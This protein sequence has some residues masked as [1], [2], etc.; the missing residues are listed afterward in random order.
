MPTVE[1]AQWQKRSHGRREIHGKCMWMRTGLRGR[2]ESRSP[3]METRGI[4]GE[5]TG[6]IGIGKLRMWIG[7]LT[8]PLCMARLRTTHMDKIGGVIGLQSLLGQRLRRGAVGIPIGSRVPAMIPGRTMRGM[9]GML[10]WRDFSLNKFNLRKYVQV[11]IQAYV[12]VIRRREEEMTSRCLRPRRMPWSRI[13][14]TNHLVRFPVTFLPLLAP[15]VQVLGEQ[16]R[17][18]LLRQ[19]PRGARTDVFRMKNGS[20][21][22]SE[23]RDQRSNAVRN[24]LWSW[25]G[26]MSWSIW[27]LPG[28]PGKTSS[29]SGSPYG[30][31]QADR[32]PW[33]PR[34]KMTS[35][36]DWIRCSTLE[37][38]RD[39]SSGQSSV[40]AM[41]L[42]DHSVQFQLDDY[43]D[44][45]LY[46]PLRLPGQRHPLQPPREEVDRNKFA[47]SWNGWQDSVMHRRCWWR[48]YRWHGFVDRI[49]VFL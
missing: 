49:L 21:G 47:A 40:G 48:V 34:R 29:S 38:G 36:A 16:V 7:C 24:L 23:S 26:S 42:P 6:A 18:F 10:R 33:T 44:R 5:G 46:P 2:Q 4:N 13:S 8:A 11:M 39:Q 20:F 28:C 41:Q 35:R 32:G 37:N 15:R 3:R 14:R 25:N 1:W 45:L 19:L 30:W 31:R 12:M 9:T 43:A 17:Q 22:F 27:L